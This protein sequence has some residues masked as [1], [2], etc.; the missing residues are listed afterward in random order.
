MSDD[1]STL[2]IE[3]FIKK[4]T[5]VGLMPPTLVSFAVLDCHSKLID[6]VHL[7]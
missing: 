7:I 1:I 2:T 3:Y 5:R 6:G 4:D